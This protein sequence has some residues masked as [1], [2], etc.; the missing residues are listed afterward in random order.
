MAKPTQLPELAELDDLLQ[1]I[2]SLSTSDLESGQAVVSKEST[3]TTNEEDPISSGMEATLDDI[4]KLVDNFDKIGAAARRH[5]QKK[6]IPRPTHEKS[7]ISGAAEGDELN[8]I[9]VNLGNVV[10][11]GVD[12][13]KISLGTC[14]YCK[15]PIIVELNESKGMKYHPEHLFCSECKQPTQ[16]QFYEHDG[17]VYCAACYERCVAPV[18]AHCHRPIVGRVVDAL[19]RKWHPEH[20]VCVVC[21]NGFPDG[22][23]FDKDNLPYCEK[24]FR[25]KFMTCKSCKQPIT[26][27]AITALNSVW[28]PEHFS[29]QICRKPF[30]QGFYQHEGLLYCEQ[31]FYEVAKVIRCAACQQPIVGQCLTALGKQWHPEHFVCSLCTNPLAPDYKE[32]DN[33]AYC[34]RCYQQLFGT[35]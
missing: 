3:S 26:G 15:K 6:P 10:I 19:E 30:G 4:N 11:R 21:G 22:K 12:L 5:L 32:K 29:C 20:F 31:H 8:E 13:N 25:A 34:P 23:F 2:S 16:G 24:D 28:H 18:C 9:L 33:K 27:K 1:E 7:I 35:K 17:R 14:V